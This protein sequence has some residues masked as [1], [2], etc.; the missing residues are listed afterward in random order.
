MIEVDN[1]SD[2]LWDSP[3]ESVYKYL[4]TRKKKL[5]Q[6]FHQNLHNSSADKDLSGRNSAQ[7]IAH[8]FPQTKTLGKKATSGEIV[9]YMEPV[10]GRV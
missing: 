7:T 3:N 9:N 2:L 5:A 4:H 8:R 1:S 6:L 10:T